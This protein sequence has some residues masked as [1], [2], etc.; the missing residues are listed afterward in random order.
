MFFPQARKNCECC[1]SNNGQG[2]PLKARFCNGTVSLNK[3]YHIM[4]H[5]KDRSSA[6]LRP[7]LNELKNSVEERKFGRLRH[8]LNEINGLFS[9]KP[10]LS[11]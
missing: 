4:K 11:A 2:Q 6:S 1:C 3:A 8:E 7:V 10:D 5:C 9:K